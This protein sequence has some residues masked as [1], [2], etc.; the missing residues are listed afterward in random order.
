M[1]QR[2]YRFRGLVVEVVVGIVVGAVVGVFVGVVAELA[3]PV[4]RHVA[5]T[6]SIA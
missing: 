6:E 5:F 3:V 2:Y 1:H 4:V